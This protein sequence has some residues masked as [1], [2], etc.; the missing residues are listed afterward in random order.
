MR[1]AVGPSAAQYL[2]SILFFVPSLSLLQ[3]SGSI[4]RPHSHGP[5][6][7]IPHCPRKVVIA[8]SSAAI[9]TAVHKERKRGEE[10]LG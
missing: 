3:Y 10:G 1:W 6:H 7:L 5:L 9:S 4:Q 2:A 8:V